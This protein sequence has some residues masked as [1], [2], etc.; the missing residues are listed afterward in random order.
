MVLEIRNSKQRKALD[1]L[2]VVDMISDL[3]FIL[4]DRFTLK[5]NRRVL[6]VKESMS[7]RLPFDQVIVINLAR[8]I[9]RMSLFAATAA[10]AGIAFERF[11]A[12]DGH[13]LQRSPIPINWQVPDVSLNVGMIGCFL[14][15]RAVL[16]KILASTWRRVLILEDDVVFPNDFH[17]RFESLWKVT[18]GTWE[19]LYLARCNWTIEGSY[20]EDRH[21]APIVIENHAVP[22]VWKADMNS[23]AYAY[24]VDRKCIPFLLESLQVMERPIDEQYAQLHYAL[25]VYAYHPAIVQHGGST[26]SDIWDVRTY[27]WSEVE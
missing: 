3:L 4:N 20:S 21:L 15:H 5:G 7:M 6:L 14:S 25:E 2:L 27:S 16:Q 19:K 23:S 10:K 1:L 12:V 18:P 22:G 8:R 11:D 9:D 24:A 26:T 13:A 17:E